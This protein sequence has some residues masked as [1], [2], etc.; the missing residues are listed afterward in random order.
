MARRPHRATVAPRHRTTVSRT[1]VG[2]WLGTRTISCTRS[3]N[4]AP[5]SRAALGVGVISRMSPVTWR[6]VRVCVCAQLADARP[7][8]AKSSRVLWLSI[9]S[10][11][12][13]S[14][15]TRA[16]GGG[17]GGE[18]GGRRGREGRGTAEPGRGKS[19]GATR[20]GEDAAATEERSEGGSGRRV[21][22]GALMNQFKCMR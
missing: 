14:W 15:W 21:G 13:G 19:D 1:K 7:V 18:A 3:R 8:Y 20:R 10:S 17:G 4:R 22:R 5:L 6:C 12:A 16:H 2:N 11:Y 9:G